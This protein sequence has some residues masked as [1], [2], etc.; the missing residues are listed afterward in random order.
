MGDAE[1]TTEP[2]SKLLLGPNGEDYL[3]NILNLINSFTENEIKT[4]KISKEQMESYKQYVIE[5]IADIRQQSEKVD[6]LG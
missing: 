4:L 2:I 5:T 6:T 1:N 3:T